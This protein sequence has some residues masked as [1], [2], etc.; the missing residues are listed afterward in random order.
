[1]KSPILMMSIR[2]RRA[3]KADARRFDIIVLAILAETIQTGRL[4]RARQLQVDITVRNR[5]GVRNLFEA[6]NLLLTWTVMREL[7]PDDRASVRNQCS[8]HVFLQSEREIQVL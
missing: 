8:Y 7:V 3:L 5:A 4:A 6:F 1:M 2:P